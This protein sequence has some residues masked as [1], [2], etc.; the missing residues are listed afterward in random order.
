MPETRSRTVVVTG[1]SLGVGRATARAFAL[2]GDRVAL[3][4]RGAE[5]LEAARAELE[6]LGAQAL[7]IPTEMADPEQVEAAAAR[8]EQA[9][10]PIDVWVND[11]MVSVFSPVKE[12]L[13]EEVRRVTEGTYLR[14]V[15]GTLAA[16]RRMLPRDARVVVQGG[17]APALRP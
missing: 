10:G 13:P 9:L 2:R 15:Y 5:S 11:A 12:L 17:S 6:A 8:A 7:A 14:T 1:A 3:L 16:P 4:A